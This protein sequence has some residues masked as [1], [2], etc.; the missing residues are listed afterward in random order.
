MKTRIGALT[1]AVALLSPSALADPLPI[2]PN[3][4]VGQS[5]WINP[6]VRSTDATAMFHVELIEVPTSLPLGQTLRIKAVVHN[7]SE[8]DAIN[9]ELQPQFAD[10]EAEVSGLRTVLAA[11]AG[12][13][14]YLGQAV[15]IPDVPAGESREVTLDITTP[16]S[17]GGV[18]PTLIGLRSAQGLESSQRFLLNVTE[19][20]ESTETTGTTETTGPTPVS[21]VYPITAAV[22][23]V[24]GE[25]GEAPQRERLILTSEALGEQLAE[26]GRLYNLVH[27]L[28]EGRVREATCV[29][30]D[31][32]LLDTVM[33]MA[34]GYQ[35]ADS[36][37]SSV[38]KKQR[39]RDSWNFSNNQSDATEGA[40]AQ[41][42]AAWL[43][44]LRAIAS[45][46][47]ALPWANT[48]L[49][50]VE[51]TGNPWLMREALQRGAE[52]FAQAGIEAVPNV[53][54]PGGGYITDETVAD[55]G[56]AD[57]A[58]GD[59]DINAA[60]ERARA[61][62]IVQA[63]GR[64][65]TATSAL[66]SN[67]LPSAQPDAPRPTTTVNV[68]VADNTVSGAPGLDRFQQ[69]AP[70]IRAVTYQGSL[71]A[72]LA[73]A[74]ESPMT[75]G[76][77]NYSARFDYTLDSLPAREATAS[78]AI[79]QSMRGEEPVL[80][81]LPSDVADP[82]TWFATLNT[83]MNTGAAM[84]LRLQDYLTPDGEQLEAL[85]TPPQNPPQSGTPYDDPTVIADTEILQARQQ[86]DYTDDLTRL[87][88]SDPQVALTPYN[89]TVPVRHE[90]LRA[91]SRNE[92]QSILTF[93]KKVATARR[94]LAW[95]R[96]MLSELRASVS[97]LPPGNVYTRLSDSS[98]LL[99]AAQNGLPLP[100][101]S[102]IRYLGPEGASI[103]VDNRLIVPAKG[104]ITVQM[105]A[106]LPTSSRTDLQLWLATPDGAA[107]SNPVDISVQTR[108]GILG[109][110]GTALAL[111]AGLA[112]I[113]L[114]RIVIRRRKAKNRM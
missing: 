32:Q 112:S 56:Y 60:W 22:D 7:R 11:D 108:S 50:A 15:A 34:Q 54:I 111:V 106:N 102:R 27:A 36:R 37:P 75:V 39:L 12:E 105:T 94:T 45:C 82:S 70:S 81:M 59:T 104:S 41:E 96:D 51:A 73:E 93:D 103:N 107:I 57:L 80:M 89:F 100:V 86:A 88:I 109:A 46:A 97:L 114:A 19:S 47:V 4:P 76:Y 33:R 71:A 68:L 18:Y 84:P 98:P 13:F 113:L 40:Y 67:T 79:T 23:I 44:Q 63:P 83:L 64:A 1:L 28:P 31:P 66:E 52:V 25:T 35:V 78:A 10:P 77:G 2:S 62:E 69:I 101:D 74:I 24:G 48:D 58:S 53:V 87:M 42:A 8:Q 55:L 91:L 99:I 3:D 49:N 9:L 43:E 30:I 90:V 17:Q 65:D 14:P 110:S 61:E 95:N 16:L 26:G 38:S 29:A 20:T 92:R 72:T 21:L 6:A 85:N 5:R